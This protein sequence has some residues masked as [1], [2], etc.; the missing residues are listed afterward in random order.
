LTTFTLGTAE[1]PH[2]TLLFGLALIG[3]SVL[4]EGRRYCH[5][6]HSEIRLY[7]LESGYFA[8]LLVPADASRAV[9]WR[10]ILADDL[11]RPR[12]RLSW[13]AGARVRLRRNYLMILYFVTAAWIT[14]LSIHP[15]W[16]GSLS[17]FY[18]RLAVGE[19]LP[20][21]FVAFTALVF[22]GGAT[23]LALTCPP[24]E[25]IEKWDRVLIRRPEPDEPA[26]ERLPTNIE[27]GSGGGV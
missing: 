22:V 1:V 11:Q 3:I 19:L 20:P 5:L 7:L 17:E 16:P 8:N 14:K 6:H 10:E 18:G 27:D 26:K 13:Y 23:G 21:W 12:L 25:E 2:F 15:G 4:M 24:A 9:D